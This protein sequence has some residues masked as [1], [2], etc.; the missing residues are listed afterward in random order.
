MNIELVRKDFPALAQK[1]YGHDLVYLDSAA[2]TLKPQA[3]IDRIQKHY[4]L[5]TSNVHRGAHYL[6]DVATQAFEAARLRTQ[7]FLKAENTEEIIFVS[8][9]TEGMNFIAQTWGL[10]QLQK[11]DEILV[12]EME[13]H[14]NIV[15]W[16]MLAERVGATLVPVQVSALGELDWKDFENKLSLKTKLVSITACSN[17]LGT[18]TDMKRIAQMAHAVGALYVVDGAQVVSQKPIDVRDIDCDFFVFS[19]HKLF[20][21]YGHGVVYGK[22]ALLEKMPPYRGGGS[23]IAKVTFE[24]T[25]YNDIPYRFEAGTPHVEGAV[26]LH[27]AIDYIEG[28][29]F[30]GIHKHEQNL[31]VYALEQIRQLDFIKL[32]GGAEDS[33]PIISFNMKGAHHSDVGQ[34]L[35]K[36][37]VAVRA[38][39]HCAQPLMA[40]L[41]VPG[42]VRAS[43]SVYNNQ[44]D[45]D[46]LVAALKKAGELLL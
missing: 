35:D 44:Q 37:G 8:G 43:F 12:S 40:K 41:G 26:G 36:E 33:G 18:N 4:A 45:V 21:P 28:L 32:Y 46:R 15:P 39:H 24:K 30:E 29:G 3:V 31:F 19:T 20:G 17:V 42:T 25:T 6:G 7:Q 34:I 22:K 13:H 10:T 1:V 27:A 14:G 9:T 5:E 38:G 23:M 16:Q 11:G 2:T